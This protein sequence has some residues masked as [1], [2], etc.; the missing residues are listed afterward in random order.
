MTELILATA[1]YAEQKYIHSNPTEHI[2]QSTLE[3]LYAAFSLYECKQTLNRKQYR[4]LL[5]EYGWDKG[6]TE[7]RRSLKIAENFQAFVGCPKHLAVLPVPIL[8]RLCS[9]NYK[10]LIE[11]LQDIPI[12]GL[13]CRLVLGLIK[14]RAKFLKSQKK[15]KK[16]GNWRATPDGNRYYTFGKIMEDDHQTGVLTDK[17][18]E[19]L[20]LSPQR[21]V[22]MAIA[23]LYDNLQT[24][25]PTDKISSLTELIT[26]EEASDTSDSEDVVNQINWESKQQEFESLLQNDTEYTEAEYPDESESDSEEDVKGVVDDTQLDGQVT[27]SS[28][29]PQESYSSDTLLE[30]ATKLQFLRSL[31]MPFNKKD[32]N[33][34]CEVV[35]SIASTCDTW[36]S[37][38]IVT[39]R[40]SMSLAFVIGFLEDEHKAWFD[41]LPK[42]LAAAA[43]TNPKELMWVD[44]VTRTKALA[45]MGFEVGSKVEVITNHHNCKGRR[46]HIVD[47]S[48]TN[49]S[50][51]GVRFRGMRKYFY[52][53]DLKLVCNQDE[54]IDGKKDIS[55]KAEI[56]VEATE[57]EQVISI[58]ENW[59]E[60][61]KSATWKALS[62]EAQQHISN[63]K[64]QHFEKLEKTPQV[65][66]KVIWNK[67]PGNLTSWQP[68]LIT[69]IQGTEAKLD[70][71]MYMVP[72][73]ELSNIT[74]RE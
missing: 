32:S 28:D 46:G 60:E 4:A 8:L 17:L 70:F 62:E 64:N 44:G 22:R 63:L 54:E 12:G 16:V 45:F 29:V 42:L 39:Q 30:L 49:K 35:N 59:T 68:F 50:P 27:F 33:F 48:M 5:E 56:L 18:I 11:K 41:N 36:K 69:D 23:N 57:W 52:Y 73:A 71:Y 7:E 10:V 53:T 14:E 47:L 15:E 43:V 51:I 26:D 61:L 13:T 21:I 37:I 55:K 9:Q 67:C 65:G 31:P 66:D 40:D 3:Y 20:G 6:T 72:L 38:A 25:I 19:Q 24:E 1:G 34:A 74:C 58:T 2:E